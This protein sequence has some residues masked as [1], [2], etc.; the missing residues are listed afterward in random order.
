MIGLRTFKLCE[1]LKIICNFTDLWYTVNEKKGSDCMGFYLNPGNKGFWESVRS[2][3]YV[4]KTNLIT[5]TNNL[6]NTKEKFVCV[7]RPRRFGK[8]ITLEMLAAYYSRGCDSAEL[9]RGRKIE[10][11]DTFQEHLNRY[12]VILLNMQQ[13][14]SRAGKQGMSEY[15]ERAV[16]NF[17]AASLC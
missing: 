16:L 7:S 4:D 2:R 13:F 10:K 9:F 1:A 5:C 11:A 14:L 3:I 6:I 8:S 17:L 15:T 12:D